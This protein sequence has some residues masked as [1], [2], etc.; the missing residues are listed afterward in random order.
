VLGRIPEGV[1][2]I[3]RVRKDAHFETACI[4]RTGKP[5]RPKSYI[6]KAPTPQELLKDAT[7]QWET[8][9]AFAAGK[10][11]DFRVKT[12]NNLRWRVAGEKRLFR[13]VVVDKIGYRLT[14]AGRLLHRD[15]AFFICSDPTLP[16][17]QV[18][19]SYMWRWGIECN[20]RDQKTL[21]G[22][23]QAQVRSETSVQKA[24][25]LT[26]AAYS[27][28]LL[29]A[30][31]ASHSGN[32]TPTLPKPKWQNYEDRPNRASTPKIIN[33]LR[34]QLWA[35]AVDLHNFRDFSISVRNNK[36]PEKF[37]NNLQ[38]A[39]FYSTQ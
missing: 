2:F 15:P 19:Q 35:S 5:G 20:F 11:R 38:S 27:M 30:V 32:K 26:V 7:V 28:L 33:E 14:K 10:Q 6:E 36:K 25:A 8:V 37:M 4:Q 12:I 16:I 17:Q 18:L 1:T 9:S 39:T 22:L 13:L 34:V 29:A 24:P 3:G 31:K 23:G 21:L